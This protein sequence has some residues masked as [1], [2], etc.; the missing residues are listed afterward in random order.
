MK[1]RAFFR[2][3]KG[4]LCLTLAMAMLSSFILPSVAAAEFIR[5]TDNIYDG[6][7]QEDQ[8]LLQA[9]LENMLIQ[10]RLEQLGLSTEEAMERIDSLTPETRA[11]VVQQIE[12]I[13]AGGEG[14]VTMSWV[15]LLLILIL[16][17]VIA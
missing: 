11:E 14:M 15:M 8:S 4:F 16:V 7:V 1:K 5:S 3:S 9:G 10:E 12:T 13:Q 6:M 2:K 17:V